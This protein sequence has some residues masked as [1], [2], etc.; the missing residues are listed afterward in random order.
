M[1]KPRLYMDS[2][3]FIDLAKSK[4]PN[5]PLSPE[6]RNDVWFTSRLLDAALDGDVEIF[7]STLTVSECTHANGDTSEKTQ[8][9]FRSLLTSGQ[10]TMLVQPDPFISED[11]ANLRWKHGI[12]LRGADAMHVASAI[13]TDCEEFLTNDEKGPIKQA[14]KIAALG[15]RVAKPHDTRLLSEKHRQEDMFPALKLK[16]KARG[17]QGVKKRASRRSAARKQ[18]K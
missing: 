2:S 16:K 9:L 4:L 5:K 13:A 18:K 7:V 10:Y 3:C 11:S 6:R 8:K 1:S 15:L 14:E 17:P 12:T